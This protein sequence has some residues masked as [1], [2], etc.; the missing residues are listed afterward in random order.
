MKLIR[1]D[2]FQADILSYQLVR[3]SVAYWIALF[4][5]ATEV[6]AGIGM[7]LRI[8]RKESALIAAVLSVVFAVVLVS[9]W[10]RG[11]DVS[12]GCFG[13]AEVKTNYPLVLG[14]DLLLLAAAVFVVIRCGRARDE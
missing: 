4:L 7:F 2:E 3:S 8:L 9:A 1:P 11:I 12:C 13:R 6:V 5:P 10:G 14:R